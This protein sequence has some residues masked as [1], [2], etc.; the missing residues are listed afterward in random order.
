MYGLFHQDPPSQGG[1]LFYVG[2]TTDIFSRRVDYH[3]SKAE[4]GASAPV[5]RY[6]AGCIDYPK[7]DLAIRELEGFDSEQEA[8]E[9]YGEGILNVQDASPA[10]YRGYPWTPDELDDL[11]RIV[12]KHSL[13]RASEELAANPAQCRHAAVKLG[14]VDDKR[15][16]S[17][18]QVLAI[19]LTYH[20]NPNVT[21]KGLAET[22]CVHPSTIGEIVRKESHQN[23]ERPSKE[24]M[25]ER[26]AQVLDGSPYVRTTPSQPLLNMRTGS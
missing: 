22:C 19:H 21:Q 9:A 26:A 20:L 16:L 24:E 17:E 11:E 1:L 25:S 3:R 18:R 4:T 7:D 10:R 23:V 12:E 14:L 6:I 15:Q 2:V 8:I 13:R 5:H